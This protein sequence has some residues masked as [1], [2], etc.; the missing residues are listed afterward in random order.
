MVK[1]SFI[2]LSLGL[3]SAVPSAFA[4]IDYSRSELLLEAPSV[5]VPVFT[6]RDKQQ[7]LTVA[8]HE[9][10]FMTD[11]KP[12]LEKQ[13]YAKVAEAFS[14][15]VIEKDSPA[16]LQLQGQ[17]L[18]TLKRYPD[19]I[20]V[21]SAAVSKAPE[22]VSAQR[23]LALAY[24]LNKQPNEARAPIQTALSLGA[25]EAALYG[26]L[27]F[28]N[29][30]QYGPWSAIA[31]YRQALFLEPTNAQW[32]QGLAH[33]LTQAHAY[34]EAG[35]STNGTNQS[36]YGQCAVVVTSRILRIESAA[37][38]KSVTSL[39]RSDAIGQNAKVDELQR[40][41]FVATRKITHSIWQYASGSDGT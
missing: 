8:P 25:N 35:V 31:G 38:R 36:R 19:A 21:L 34:S 26:Q 6:Y 28:L 14:G 29:L 37:I 3:F 15:R 17:V 4:G 39:G 16:L 30:Q 5:S 18:L 1:F 27:A 10:A 2:W 11:L 13:Q 24:I 7:S 40:G 20:K 12:L 9:A 32:K 23:S 33:A 22:L 41:Q